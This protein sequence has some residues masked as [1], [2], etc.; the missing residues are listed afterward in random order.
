MK[1]YPAEIKTA[2]PQRSEAASLLSDSVTASVWLPDYV[3]RLRQNIHRCDCPGCE[4]ASPLLQFKWRN[5]IRH[6]ADISCSRAAAEILCPTASCTIVFSEDAAE[7]LPELPAE[8]LEMNRRCLR[9]F[10][11]FRA[12]PALLLYVLGCFIR[13]AATLAPQQRAAL[14]EEWLR[15]TACQQLMQHFFRDCED[16][17]YPPLAPQNLQ[18]LPLWLP[19]DRD[20]R[21]QKLQGMEQMNGDQLRQKWRKLQSAS[22]LRKRTRQKILSNY[23]FYELCHNF[24]PGN[25]QSDWESN[26]ASLCRHMLTLKLLLT[27]VPQGA[28]KE[29]V[30]ALFAAGYRTA[31]EQIYAK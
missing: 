15:P 8:F 31:R 11:V 24:F 5:H 29:S 25:F 21:L 6:S 13:E 4:G 17:E 1:N 18:A 16:R 28:D 7:H 2:P 30:G 9:L 22:G 14:A 23:L 3:L 26:F 20:A 27:V 12:E 19:I 10:E